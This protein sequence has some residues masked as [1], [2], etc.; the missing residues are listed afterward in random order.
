M[1]EAALASDSDYYKGLRIRV[2]EMCRDRLI[3]VDLIL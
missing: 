3:P 1:F 2:S